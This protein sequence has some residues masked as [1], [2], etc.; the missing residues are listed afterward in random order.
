[1]CGHGLLDLAAYDDYL[2]GELRDLELSDK[3]IE[4]ALAGLP[5]PA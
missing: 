1:L 2:S 3:V 5:T 4:T